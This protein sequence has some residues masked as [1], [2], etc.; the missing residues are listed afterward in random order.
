M[1]ISPLGRVNGVERNL[2]VGAAAGGVQS[3]GGERET[4]AAAEQE[5]RKGGH[6]PEKREK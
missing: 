1:M 3:A 6:R 4:A 2:G 5:G